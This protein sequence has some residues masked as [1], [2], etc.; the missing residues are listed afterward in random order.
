M[1]PK[2]VSL[3]IE[4]I[5]VLIL[6]ISVLGVLLFYFNKEASSTQSVTSMMREITNRCSDYIRLDPGCSGKYAGYGDEKKSNEA[7]AKKIKDGII[8]IC[9]RFSK[10]TEKY[11]K[12]QESG[13]DDECFRQCCPFCY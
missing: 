7:E 11:P 8:V 5:I 10:A 3:S 2:G 13:K 1:N 12:C 9:K 4:T 6:A